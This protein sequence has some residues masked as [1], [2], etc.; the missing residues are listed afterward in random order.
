MKT[1]LLAFA[2]LAFA[3]C[4]SPRPVPVA[5]PLAPTV[6]KPLPSK[7]V[8]LSPVNT[9]LKPVAEAN[10]QLRDQLINGRRSITELNRKLGMMEA[11]RQ[12]TLEEWKRLTVLGEDTRKA[13]DESDRI[14]ADQ[15]AA[16][17]GLENSVRNATQDVIASEY[18]KRQLIANLDKANG[19][20]EQV[21]AA[22]Q[23]AAK[24]AQEFESKVAVVKSERDAE[25]SWKW[26]FFWWGTVA[27]VLLAGAGYLILKP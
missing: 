6:V 27:T 20:I 2:V 3:G 21:T 4:N 12:A 14:Q 11:S 18:E 10:R 13:L 8:D 15:K 9:G 24:S 7:P 23:D 22:Q 26:K 19:I 16:I 1:L 17:E 5:I 25:R